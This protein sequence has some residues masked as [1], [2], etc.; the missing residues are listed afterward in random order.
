M[1]SPYR[2]FLVEDSPAIRETLAHSLESSGQ[3]TIVGH[4]ETADDACKAL[5]ITA[6]DAVIVDLHLRQGT[7]FDLLTRLKGVPALSHLVKI[8]LTNYAAKTF[9]DR[10]MVLGANY[11]FDKSL[12]F[13]QVIDVLHGLAAS[14]EKR[15]SVL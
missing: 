10:C 15:P 14:R 6:A 12:E 13:D 3:L 1:E 2:V 8:V 5:E 4:A 7:G 9:R 11:F